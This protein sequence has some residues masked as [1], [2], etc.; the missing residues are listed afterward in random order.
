MKVDYLSDL[1]LNHWINRNQPLEDQEQKTRALINQ[2]IHNKQ[3]E[4][5]VIAGDFGKWNIHS[6]WVLEECSK[7]YERVYFTLGLHD[8][9]LKSTDDT[10]RDFEERV[11]ELF[12]MIAHLDNVKLLSKTVDTYK[13]KV[14]AG[15]ILW[16]QPEGKEWDYLLYP[17]RHPRKMSQE[18]I[19]IKEHFKEMC[20][21]SMGWY[22][23]LE[24]EKIDVFV[25]YFPP[26]YCSCVD[27]R[28]SIYFTDT[29]RKIKLPFLASKNWICGH[30]HMNIS[31]E[32]DET[33]M[34]MNCFGFP[35]DYSHYM[36]RKSAEKIIEEDIGTFG[37]RTIEI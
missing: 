27:M 25:S 13:G 15:D 1:H 34:Y 26:T 28:H 5:L 7:Q 12:E 36:N 24:N 29:L 8:L 19:S 22:N 37:I 21:E 32:I 2:L 33:V 17:E 30:H 6:Y 14:F 9:Y 23:S 11:N 35:D 31:T 16:Y 10:Y 4:V 20:K 18:G 3:G